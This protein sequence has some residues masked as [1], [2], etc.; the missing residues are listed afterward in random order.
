M[1]NTVRADDPRRFRFVRCG[2]HSRWR[3]RRCT[4]SDCALVGVVQAEFVNTHTG[5]VV[6]TDTA[7][8]PWWEHEPASH[9]KML[10]RRE[11]QHV[12]RHLDRYVGT[13]DH[14]ELADMVEPEPLGHL[15]YW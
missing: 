9:R 6:S 15:R 7:L 4:V 11:R 2:H 10:R 12:R 8:A 3:L 5:T 14:D 1:S 13:V